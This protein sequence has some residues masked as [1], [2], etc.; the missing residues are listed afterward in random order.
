MTALPKLMASA[1]TVHK[2]AIRVCV[3]SQR[4]QAMP[5]MARKVMGI[6]PRAWR[7]ASRMSVSRKGSVR[8]GDKVTF[9]VCGF[10]YFTEFGVSAAGR[11]RPVY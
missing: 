9:C 11:P 1:L 6:P 3:S 5:M 10:R 4:I 2:G 7:K 8:R